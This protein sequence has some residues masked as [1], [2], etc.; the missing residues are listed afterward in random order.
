M[1]CSLLWK[2]TEGRGVAG[3]AR[4]GAPT[5]GERERERERGR[6]RGRERERERRRVVGVGVKLI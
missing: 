6:E 3:A 1:H 4:K 2:P 5:E